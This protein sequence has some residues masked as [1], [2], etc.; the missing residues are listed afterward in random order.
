M[1]KE[2]LKKYLEILE[3][4]VDMN[5]EEELVPSLSDIKEAYQ[6]LK[7]LYTSEAMSMVT[8]PIEDEFSQEDQEEI[9]NQ[10][11]EAYNALL[12]YMVEKDRVEKEAFKKAGIMED[13][14]AE[15][16]PGESREDVE[17]E[18]AVSEEMEVLELP[19]VEE[20]LESQELIELPEVPEIPEIPEAEMV[21]EVPEALEEPEEVEEPQEEKEPEAMEAEDVPEISEAPEKPGEPEK[22]KEAEEREELEEAEIAEGDTPTEEELQDKGL[23]EQELDKSVLE[24]FEEFE[25]IEAAASTPEP[26]DLLKQGKSIKGRTLRKAREKLEVGIHEM[27]VSTGISYKVLVNI[28]KERYSKLPEPGYLRWLITTYAKS[29]SLDPKKAADDY[30]KRYRQWERNQEE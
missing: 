29:L 30:M 4:D 2:T 16:I 19:E 10:L 9:L 3:L 25:D 21:P 8:E 17:E 23:K 6:R 20:L 26:G 27:A 22:L 18:G 15:Y 14:V 11:E 13:T 1:D 24:E 12:H 7:A 28:E 5:G